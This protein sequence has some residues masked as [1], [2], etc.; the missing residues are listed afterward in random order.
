V[1]GA[2]ATYPR[3]LVRPHLGHTATT[4]SRASHPPRCAPI[5]GHAPQAYTNTTH[6]PLSAI[7]NLSVQ[8]MIGNQARDQCHNQGITAC[9]QG[10]VHRVSSRDHQEDVANQPRQKVRTRGSQCAPSPLS[11][12]TTPKHTTG[13]APRAYAA[14]S[15]RYTNT[16]THICGTRGGVVERKARPPLPCGAGR[17]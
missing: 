13:H 8:S 2:N 17:V 11:F 7:T 14:R 3:K 10:Y 12:P 9:R 1:I 5:R 4:R 6:T 16:D 15:V